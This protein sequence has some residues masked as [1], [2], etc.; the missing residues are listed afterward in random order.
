M[1]VDYDFIRIA[2]TSR[3]I[4]LPSIALQK[5]RR[6]RRWQWHGCCGHHVSK[7]PKHSDIFRVCG[8]VL[9]L[10]SNPGVP[11]LLLRY[12]PILPPSSYTLCVTTKAQ[13]IQCRTRSF[14]SA[15][16]Y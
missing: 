9:T 1:Q 8:E 11:R 6:F 12:L 3:P 14:R 16:E 13:D 7:C 4:L 15:A 5:L 10:C 2:I